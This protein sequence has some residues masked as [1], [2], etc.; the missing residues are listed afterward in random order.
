MPGMTRR[1]MLLDASRPTLKSLFEAY[2]RLDE[3]M[4]AEVDDLMGA[5]PEL[6]ETGF[7]EVLT[8]SLSEQMFDVA[9]CIL[10]VA[11]NIVK[12][13]MIESGL[14]DYRRD[15]FGLLMSVGVRF[16]TALHH[17]ANAY[18]HY[19]EWNGK[20]PDAIRF[21]YTA[22][23]LDLLGIGKY[24]ASVSHTILQMEGIVHDGLME[25]QVDSILA[26]ADLTTGT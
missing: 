26:D 5:A 19:P 9:G 7:R 22:E 14:K 20:K 4:R 17:G 15:G 10:V 16:G 6:E 1:L 11:D 8:N 21:K 24:D 18:R 2:K 12:T 25:A 3:K 23:A 13:Y